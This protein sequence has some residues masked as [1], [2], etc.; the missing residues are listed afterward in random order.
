VSEEPRTE[1][2]EEDEQRV[3]L[4]VRMQPD[5]LRW[6]ELQLGVRLLDGLYTE[7]ATGR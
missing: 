3:L 1:E 2:T 5:E 7:S 4:P 6:W